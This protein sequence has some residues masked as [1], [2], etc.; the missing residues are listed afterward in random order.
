[1]PFMLS[2]GGMKGTP[3]IVGIHHVT[4][5]VTD[6]DRTIAW[7]RDVLGF[8]ELRRLSIGGMD[9][10]MLARESLTLTLVAH[11]DKTVPGRFDERRVGLDHLSFAVAD[12]S[13]LQDWVRH[14][15]ENHVTHSEVTQ[16]TA[17]HLVAFRD[18]DNIALEFYTLT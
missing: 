10:A 1:M 5:S 14:L 15:D 3:S 8:A 4:F 11:G 2:T 7:Y 16:A 13:A 12:E 9:K 18:P 6:L 17:G